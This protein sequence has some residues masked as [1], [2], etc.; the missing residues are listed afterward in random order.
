MTY[1]DLTV[2]FGAA[3]NMLTSNSAG[4]LITIGDGIAS[5]GGGSLYV[6]PLAPA[7]GNIGKIQVQKIS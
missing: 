2:V 3:A 6:C 7:Y 4:S 5:F 1:I